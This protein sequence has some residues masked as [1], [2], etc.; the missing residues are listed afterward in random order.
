MIFGFSFKLSSDVYGTLL[1]VAVINSF[2]YV[3][4]RLLLMQG[5]DPCAQD[6]DGYTPAHYAVEKDDVEML[7]ALIVRIHPD[8]KTFSESKD[9]DG[10]TTLHYAVARNNLALTTFLI[11]E[12][13]ADVNGGETSRPS[14]L[15]VA[16]FNNHPEIKEF[17]L[18]N[19]AKSRFNIKCIKFKSDDP[20]QD[21][22]VNLEGLTLADTPITST[23]SEINRSHKQKNSSLQLDDLSK[24]AAE[25]NKNNDY[26]NT[27]KCYQQMVN[28][29]LE[30]SE[31]EMVDSEVAKIYN[32]IAVVYHRQHNYNMALTYYKKAVECVLTTTNYSQLGDYYE[33]I[34]LTY[35]TQNKN[36]AALENFQ[37]SLNVRR[38]NLQPDQTAIE[39]IE[40]FIENV[41]GNIRSTN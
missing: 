24:Q 31:S 23:F 30:N 1:H 32:S 2:Q 18:L 39:R 12:C 5:A 28:I 8:V 34:G 13:L 25:F 35:A 16:I 6:R 15:D 26:D 3:Y 21:I 27:L 37:N 33:N 17:L 11:T 29:Y 36:A 9:L 38:S 22:Q 14:P 7:K 10:D 4:V 40:K 41:K 19:N 20:Q